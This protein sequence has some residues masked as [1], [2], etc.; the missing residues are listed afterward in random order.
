MEEERYDL[1]N[2]MIELVDLMLEDQQGLRS[3]KFWKM[4]INEQEYQGNA[5][6][7]N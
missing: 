4:E 6:I 7:I 2:Y 3:D 5:T 1:N